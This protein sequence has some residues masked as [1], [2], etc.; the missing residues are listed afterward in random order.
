[1]Q[2]QQ[3]LNITK[4]LGLLLIAIGII[5]WTISIIELTSNEV[6]LTQNL[7][8]E[9]MW[10]YEGALQWWQNMYTTAIIPATVAL[11]IF[12]ILL[13]LSPRLRKYVT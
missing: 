6:M 8:A 3:Q 12:G 4:L 13:I 7:S 9:D 10:R 5:I 2:K 11:I 1:M